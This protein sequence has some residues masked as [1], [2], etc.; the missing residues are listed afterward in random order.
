MS[1]W[2]SVGQEHPDDLLAD[3]D[4]TLPGADE[5]RAATLAAEGSDGFPAP[6]ACARRWDFA[7]ARKAWGDHCP[8]ESCQ[9]GTFHTQP[10]SLAPPLQ[11][12]FGA[13]TIIYT[14]PARGNSLFTTSTYAVANGRG[15]GGHEYA[16]R[17]RCIY[18]ERSTS[19]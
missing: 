15:Y 2:F 4:Q 9:W 17:G 11:S 12:K 3:L 18:S 7:S 16:K 10:Q 5:P 19:R 14:I 13:E 6:Q 1:Q 8:Q